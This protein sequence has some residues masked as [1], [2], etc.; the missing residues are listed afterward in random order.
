MHITL[1]ATTAILLA[2]PSAAF[3]QA[4]PAPDALLRRRRRR[5]SNRAVLA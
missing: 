4:A 1:R 5:L 3:A 2:V